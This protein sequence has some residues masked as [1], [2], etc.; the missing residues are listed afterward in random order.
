M[1]NTNTNAITNKWNNIETELL[2]RSDEDHDID[3]GLDY[4]FELD[5]WYDT[6]YK[7]VPLDV[8]SNEIDKRVRKY[9]KLRGKH[10]EFYTN[11][12]S[13]EKARDLVCSE[14]SRNSYIYDY[15][16]DESAYDIYGR[17]IPGAVSIYQVY[18]YALKSKEERNKERS[19]AVGKKVFFCTN[20]TNWKEYEN[21]EGFVVFDD[22]Y[23]RRGRVLD[24]DDYKAVY[25]MEKYFCEVCGMEKMKN[26]KCENK[27]KGIVKRIAKTWARICEWHAKI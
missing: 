11:V 12:D 7:G 20:T 25:K 3:Y 27:C 16:V 23:D 15:I 19:K 17:M 10:V 24:F 5:D 9:S 26:G 22:A 14:L 6:A 8:N 4:P 2:E 21:E 18:P 13:V 1:E